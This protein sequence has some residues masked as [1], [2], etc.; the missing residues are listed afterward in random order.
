MTLAAQLEIKRE[1]EK[2]ALAAAMAQCWKLVHSMSEAKPAEAERTSHLLG[3]MVKHMPKLPLE[4]KRKMLANARGFEC[5]ANMRAVDGALRLAFEKARHGEPAERNRL[6]AEARKFRSKAMRLGA[7]ANFEIA[8]ERKIEI[9]ML[10]GGVEHKGPT[11]A[12]PRFG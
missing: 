1:T 8:A 2:R 3:E 12:K 7:E 11:L 10:T 4:F 5:A 6:L 9:I